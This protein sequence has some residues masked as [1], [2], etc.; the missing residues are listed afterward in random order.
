M[1]CHLLYLFLVLDIAEVHQLLGQ[2]Y[3]A[4]VVHTPRDH[5]CNQVEGINLSRFEKQGLDVLLDEAGIVVSLLEHCV[6]ED[7]L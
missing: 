2:L 5:S 4:G 1:D 6:V 7:S 3:F